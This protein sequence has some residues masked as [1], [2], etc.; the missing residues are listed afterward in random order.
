VEHYIQEAIKLQQECHQL[1]SQLMR[2]HWIT[3]TLGRAKLSRTCLESWTDVP[4]YSKERWIKVAGVCLILFLLV[5]LKMT[6]LA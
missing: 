2:V 6:M 4:H 1:R 5:T 3:R